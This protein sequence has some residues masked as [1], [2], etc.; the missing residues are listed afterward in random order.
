[1]RSATLSLNDIHAVPRGA[2][3]HLYAEA[4]VTSTQP[5]SRCFQPAACVTSSTTRVSVPATASRTPARSSRA[6]SADC[7]RLPT[8]TSCSTAAS[9]NRSGATSVTVTPRPACA[10]NGNDVLVNSPVT[11]ATRLPSGTDA[12]TRPNAAEVDPARTTD[13]VGTPVRAAY[14][15]LARRT[16][17]SND[18]AS[19]VPDCH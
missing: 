17:S 10:A 2:S 1:M 9:G 6:P 11:T 19:S 13:S 18:A 3:S 8:T 15:A 4:T 12:A 16:G 5:R 7:T 14:P